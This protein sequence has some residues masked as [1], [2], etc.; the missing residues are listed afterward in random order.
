MAR[1]L[2][3]LSNLLTVDKSANGLDEKTESRAVRLILPE[4][5]RATSVAVAHQLRTTIEFDE[6]VVLNA[7]SIVKFG[8]PKELPAKDEG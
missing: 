3:R 6:I 8:R 4:F 7:G 1:A 2:L 5:K